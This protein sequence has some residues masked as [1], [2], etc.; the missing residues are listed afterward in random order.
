M[1]KAIAKEPATLLPTAQGLA[2]DLRRFLE[3]KPIK[4]RRPSLAE[5]AAKWSRRH[6]SFVES[7]MILMVV[8]VVGLAIAAA[9]ISAAYRSESRQCRLLA[10]N[11][12]RHSRRS[13][14]S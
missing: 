12:S 13:T 6:R 7:A 2:D 1:L 14:R 4:A 5:R 11:L 8:G 3:D 9:L 10:G